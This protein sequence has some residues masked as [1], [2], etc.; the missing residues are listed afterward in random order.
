[1]KR[2][3]SSKLTSKTP[4]PTQGVAEAL[5]SLKEL[6]TQAT[7][8]GMA[9]FAIPSDHALGVASARNRRFATIVENIR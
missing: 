7:L 8:D 5:A 4:K 2:Q 6:A 3:I 9:R 1:M